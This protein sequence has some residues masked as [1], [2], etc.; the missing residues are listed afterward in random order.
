MPDAV[1]SSAGR[2]ICVFCGAKPGFDPEWAR[3]A[4]ACGGAIARRGWRL[5]YG[6]GRVGLMGEMADA[7]LLAGGEVVG[8]IPEG[9]LSREV[10]HAG[11][12]R[13]E[14]VPDMAVRKTRMVEMADA[15]VTLPGGLGTLDE[16]FEVLTLRQTR[17]H[18][19][20]VGLLNARAYWDPLLRACT[21]MVEA[22]F[23]ST[24]DLD[25]LLVADDIETLLERLFNSPV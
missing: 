25:C 5:V 15:F 18:R 20:P 16:L 1:A 10:G 11:L 6:G 8:V 4:R 23:V 17:Y 22:G 24:S 12:T 19:K 14:V 13:L 9:L 21:G 7:A 2:S 3:L